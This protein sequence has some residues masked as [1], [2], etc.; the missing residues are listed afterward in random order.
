MTAE[1]TSSEKPR[2]KMG[3]PPG[4]GEPKTK[5]VSFRL[6]FE[7]IDWLKSQPGSQAQTISRLIREAQEK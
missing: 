3:R 6:K 5:M 1:N 4:K 7:D 2:R